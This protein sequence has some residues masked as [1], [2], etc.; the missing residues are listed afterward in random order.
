MVYQPKTLHF[1]SAQKHSQKWVK[2][3]VLVDDNENNL[4]NEFKYGYDAN[5]VRSEYED[6]KVKRREWKEKEA[7]PSEKPPEDI[8]KDHQ[9]SLI[10]G[11]YTT[12]VESPR[13]FFLTY[14]MKEILKS[15]VLFS[16]ERS[17]KQ[18]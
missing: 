18:S 4:C 11:L 6:L 3:K 14:C 10:F 17:K 2:E 5:L 7:G 8:L 16:I 12:H 15:P 13:Y 9:V 1:F